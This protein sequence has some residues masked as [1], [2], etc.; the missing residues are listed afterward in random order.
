MLTGRV[1]FEAAVLEYPV[2][3]GFK[4]VPI[5]N[6]EMSVT[7]GRL[8]GSNVFGQGHFSITTAGGKTTGKILS[9]VQTCNLGQASCFLLLEG[10]RIEIILM[11]G[12]L[13]CPDPKRLD[14]H[15]HF[16]VTERLKLRLEVAR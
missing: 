6:G 12:V 15:I 7:Q 8:E 14:L 13:E 1:D 16:F 9:D 4:Q 2:G 10:L 5:F 11:A 3:T